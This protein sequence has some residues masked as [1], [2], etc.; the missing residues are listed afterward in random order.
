[1]TKK[2]TPI[3]RIG[4]S[5]YVLS[6]CQVDYN[7]ILIFFFSCLYKRWTF[8]TIKCQQCF[9]TCVFKF[10]RVDLNEKGLYTILSKYEIGEKGSCLHKFLYDLKYAS[11]Q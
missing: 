6:C 10:L 4:L 2:N 3:K 1:M 5:W 11:C 9:S 8:E 7:P